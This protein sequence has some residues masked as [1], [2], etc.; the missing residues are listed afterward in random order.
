MR[1]FSQTVFLYHKGIYCFSLIDNVIVNILQI[2]LLGIFGNLLR[3]LSRGGVFKEL[4]LR[5]KKGGVVL[6]GC[7]LVNPG[8]APVKQALDH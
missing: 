6:C 2:N 5:L 4:C 8:S 7:W 3:I 1:L